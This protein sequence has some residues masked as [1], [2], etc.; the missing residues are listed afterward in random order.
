MYLCIYVGFIGVYIYVCNTYLHIRMYVCMIVYIYVYTRM[1]TYKYVVYTNVY[2]YIYV[3]THVFIRTSTNVYTY[4]V[5]SLRILGFIGA[6]G[7]SVSSIMHLSQGL[8]SIMQLSQGLKSNM[9]LSQGL[10]CTYHK[11]SKFTV[12]VHLLHQSHLCKVRGL[13]K[14]INWTLTYVDSKKRALHK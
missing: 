8:K 9:L 5:P 1:Y 7:S 13:L 10:S 6:G 4:L 14:K 3:C 2:E 12:Q 11:V